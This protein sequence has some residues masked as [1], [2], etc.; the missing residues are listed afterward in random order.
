[1]SRIPVVW[2]LSL[3]FLPA[4]WAQFTPQGGKIV[5]IE[6]RLTTEQGGSLALCADG[7]TAIV[8]GAYGA[9]GGVWIY[10]R[11]NG[12]WSLQ[13]RLLNT[14]LNYGGDEGIYVAISADGNTAIVGGSSGGACLDDLS[15]CLGETG[16]WI[17]TRNNGV[18]TQQGDKLLRASGAMGSYASVRSVAISAD[19]NLAVA[20]ADDATNFGG[21]WVLTRSNGVWSVWGKLVGNMVGPALEGLSVALSGDA[22]TIAIGGPWDNNSAGA[23]WIFT[24]YNGVWIQQAKLSGTGQ[25]GSAVALSADG[26]TLVAGAPND[27]LTGT[28]SVFSRTDGIWTQQ[29][30]KLV[31]LRGGNGPAAQG[32]AVGISGDGNTVVVGGPLDWGVSGLDVTGGAWIFV[33]ANGA[34]FQQESPLAGSGANSGYSA[35]GPAFGASVAISADGHT[36]MVGAPQDSGFRGAVWAFVKPSSPLPVSVSMGSPMTFTFTDGGGWQNLSIVSVLINNAL[37]DRQT[38]SF[39]FVPSGADSGTLY[40]IDDAGDAAGPY[41]TLT[42]PG[43]GTAA[44]SQCSISGVG[45]SVAAAGNTLTLSLAVQFNPAFAGKVIYA[46]AQDASMTSGWRPAG[47]FA[48]AG[49][50]ASNGTYTF[51]FTGSGVSIADVLIANE[52][53]SISACYFAFLPATGTLYLV[54]DGGDAAGPFSSIVLPGSGTAS[55]SQCAISGIGASVAQSGGTL[56]LTLPIAFSPAFTGNQIVYMAARGVSQT[57]GWFIGG[58][59]AIP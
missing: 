25:M 11:T 37:D 33:R 1:M 9:G 44:N 29:G 51:T 43:A 17:F 47:T 54:E 57:T 39:G 19:G 38:C 48:A 24:L 41:A 3:F 10:A 14:D 36:A 26:N 12:I 27:G 52:L 50:S 53:N 21:A 2:G 4:A 18:W 55:N 30:N 6:K 58:V 7:N 34:W 5:T 35:F 46:A 31:G 16:V 32:S 13:A 56:T 45:S 23:V 20:G 22:Q 42:L 40:L 49:M 8:G 15:P 28:A 59:I